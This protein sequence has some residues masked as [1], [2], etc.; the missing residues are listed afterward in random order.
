MSWEQE[1]RALADDGDWVVVFECRSLAVCQELALV[2]QALAIDC[3]ISAEPRHALLVPGP[4]A[5]RANEQLLAYLSEIRKPVPQPPPAPRQS[6]GIAGVVAYVALLIMF[7]YWQSHQS[8]GVAWLDSG[9]MDSTAVL[10]GQWWR[11]VTALTLHLDLAHLVGNL[12]FGGA[13]GYFA[14]Q[15]FGTGLAWAG[16][17]LGGSLGNYLNA[18]L[19]GPGHRSIGASTAIFAALG[20][21]SAFTWRR[22]RRPDENLLRR[23]SPIF[24]GIALLAY[25]GAGGERTDV[26]AHLTGFVCGLAI[27]VAYGAA[28]KRILLSAPA[29]RILVMLALFVLMLSWMLAIQSNSGRLI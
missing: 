5:N 7:A 20:L 16:I 11:S 14:G 24:A 15:L 4:V 10:S 2:L 13:F 12:V 25:T 23:W 9:R 21:L 3:K 27:G 17:L 22:W 18:W 6:S 1:D 8:F 19:Q 29:Q 26:V 28:G